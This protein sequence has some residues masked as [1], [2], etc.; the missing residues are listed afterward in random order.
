MS[1]FA[2]Y[3]GR[4][5]RELPAYT[6]AEASR[7]V[8]VPAATLRSWFSGRTYPRVDGVGSFEPVLAPADRR[9]GHLSF[10]N[11]V[12]AHVLRALRT[13]HGIR[14]KTVRQALK[15]A[16]QRLG[17]Q[18]LL[19]RN[20]ALVVGD[21]SLF[22]E[23]YGELL[24]LDLSEQIAMRRVLEAFLSRVDW[25]DRDIPIRLYPFLRGAENVRRSIVIDPQVSFG[26]PILAES[27]I[28]TSALVQRINAGERID[29]VARDYDI[30][31]TDVETAI[32]FEKAA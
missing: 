27:G 28:S 9:T 32:L 7:Y 13:R 15:T 23:Y 12:E 5:P 10:R 25:D 21:R 14:L 8:N 3:Q 2:L 31:P 30:T 4:D 11:V 1:R 16:E 20:K 6:V 26:R 18:D 24:H 29:A 19:Y 22:L 17:I